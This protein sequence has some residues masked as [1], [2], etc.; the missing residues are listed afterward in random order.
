MLN[1]LCI[2]CHILTFHLIT[3]SRSRGNFVG[4]YIHRN[5]TNITD[6]KCTQNEVNYID[7]YI[8]AFIKLRVMCKQLNKKQRRICFGTYNEIRFG[9]RN[10]KKTNEM[11][12]I[13]STPVLLLL[14]FASYA[15]Q[16]HHLSEIIYE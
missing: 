1:F 11:I 12:L 3:F 6:V 7:L 16:H 10:K 15:Y 4:D 5:Y 8:N 13:L 14:A 2:V 9:K